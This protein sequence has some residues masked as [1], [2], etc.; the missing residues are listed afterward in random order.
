M[1]IMTDVFLKMHKTVVATL[2]LRECSLLKL[3]NDMLKV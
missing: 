1:F 3:A 2:H